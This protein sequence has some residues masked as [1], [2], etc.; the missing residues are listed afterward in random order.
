MFT[1]MEVGRALLSS[2]PPL[3]TRTHLRHCPSSSVLMLHEQV[4]VVAAS[5]PITSV[6]QHFP[7]SVLLQEQR[8][9]SKPLLNMIKEDRIS[10]EMLDRRE[11]EV[12]SSTLGENHDNLDEL[13]L[14][15]GYQTLQSPIL[16]NLF[17]A[18]QTE[19]KLS[20][21]LGL[22]SVANNTTK[23]N[24][25]EPSN[26]IDI[27]KKA[28][29][30]SREAALFA[31]TSANFDNSV[32]TSLGSPSS[33][34]SHEDVKI[35]RSTRRRELQSKN[36]RLPKTKDTFDELH[37]LRRTEIRKNTSEEFDP[38]DPL[39]LFLWG[40]E[41]KQL[42]TAKEESELVI[43]VQELL[44]LEAVKSKLQSHF[45]REPTLVEWAE[46]VELNCMVL[47][48]RIRSGNRSREKLIHANLR[49][50][51]HIA[52]RYQ[53]RGVGLQDL[54]QEGSMGLMK[55]VEKFKPQA[56]CRFATYAYWWI[57]QTVRKALFQHSRTIR[58]PESVYSLLGKIMEAKRSCA[59]EGDHNPSKEEVARRAG[60]TV[61]KLEKLLY[62]TRAPI[63]MQQPVWTD[64]D[65]TFQEITADSEIE[66]PELS[67]A[68]RL[69][70]KHVRGLLNILN[71]RERHIIRL[72]F[73]IEDGKQRSLSEI[74]GLFGLTKERVRQL[75]SRA[76]NKLKQCLGKHGL[77][78]YTDLLV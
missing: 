69:M 49:M 8:D 13:L 26:V 71:P 42:L 36:R 16:R 12:N 18:L 58:L 53:G 28:L 56:G 7:A 9:D 17:T 15:F 22:Q 51:V 57:R 25:V 44:K 46:A 67:V 20:L 29:S 14:Q 41:T 63:S 23:F 34:F 35:V 52:K 54:L 72:R 55:S 40:P 78:A 6:A 24:D 31:D 1:E 21:S 27:A 60:I 73:G 45:G 3:P 10:Q 19:Q 39:R 50:V 75:E 33:T 48:S 47:Q 5:I 30:A 70:R 61:N 74:G 2:S 37:N 64:Q 43:Q 66:I 38:N 4:A 68:K 77:D 11:I 32:S 65:T 62:M 76:L 59:R